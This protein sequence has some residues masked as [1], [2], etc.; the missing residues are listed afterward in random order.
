[1]THHAGELPPHTARLIAEAYAGGASVDAL[2][3]MHG[4]GKATIQ[5]AIE[6]AGVPLRG[7]LPASRPRRE[8]QMPGRATRVL[9][10]IFVLVRGPEDTEKE[11]EPV[12]ATWETAMEKVEAHLRTLGEAGAIPAGQYRMTSGMRQATVLIGKARAT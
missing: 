11:Y 7:H 12:A 1:M 4:R 3:R 9:Q 10:P 8:T 5:A 6:D 2:R